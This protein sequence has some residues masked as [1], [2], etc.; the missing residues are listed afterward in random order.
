LAVKQQE[1]ADEKI[2]MIFAKEEYERH[3]KLFEKG[4]KTEILKRKT[5]ILK[6]N[7]NEL[8]LKILLMICIRSLRNKL[9]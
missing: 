7:P 2:N 4:N 9:K 1:E 5:E 6:Y 8:Q 3:T